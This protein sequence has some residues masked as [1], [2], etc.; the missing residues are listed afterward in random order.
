[1]QVAN[2]MRPREC[3]ATRLQFGAL[4][5]PGQEKAAANPGTHHE[6]AETCWS[7]RMLTASRSI[8]GRLVQAFA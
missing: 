6:A 5:L 3:A 2:V 8:C 4:R 1:M 7:V